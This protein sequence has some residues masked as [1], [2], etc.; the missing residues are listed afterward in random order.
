MAILLSD[1]IND[2]MLQSVKSKSAEINC[3]KSP[4]K[5]MI[6]II[7]GFEPGTLKWT[8]IATYPQKCNLEVLDNSKFEPRNTSMLQSMLLQAQ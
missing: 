1:I 4:E 5:Q 6:I 7:Q 8:F 2:K 3:S